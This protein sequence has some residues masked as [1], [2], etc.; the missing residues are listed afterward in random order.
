MNV[1]FGD[2]LT[3]SQAALV[4]QVFSGITPTLVG[5]ELQSAG[6]SITTEEEK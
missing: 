5:Q 2:N 6:S 1:S 4:N 3:S